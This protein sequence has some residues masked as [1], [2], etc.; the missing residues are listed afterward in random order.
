MFT[1]DS[2]ENA[3]YEGNQRLRKMPIV[4]STQAQF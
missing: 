1:P 4:S 3:K 2:N